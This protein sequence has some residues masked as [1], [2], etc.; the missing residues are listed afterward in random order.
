MARTRHIEKRMNQ[1]GIKGCLLDAVEQFGVWNGDKLILNRKGAS[2]A[3]NE[4]D[5]MRKHL[6]EVEGKGGIALVQGRG[7]GITT[8]AL[9]SYRRGSKH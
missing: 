8:Y 6:I 5:R 1:R 4:L 9:D 7:V 3:I 2:A